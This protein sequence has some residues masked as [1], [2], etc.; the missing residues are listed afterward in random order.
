MELSVDRVVQGPITRTCPACGLLFRVGRGNE[1]EYPEDPVYETSSGWYLRKS[2]GTVLYFPDLRVLQSWASDGMIS[3]TDEISKK[4]VEWKRVHDLPEFASLA[5]STGSPKDSTA[6]LPRPSPYNESS[7]ASEEILTELEFIDPTVGRKHVLY[8]LMAFIIGCLGTWFLVGFL[9]P[10]SEVQIPPEP[11]PSKSPAAVI[12]SPK[13]EGALDVTSSSPE[14]SKDSSSVRDA[15][16]KP[17]DAQT[18]AV[19]S[20]SVDEDSVEKEVEAKPQKKKSRTK[21]RRVG[22]K[23]L[24]YDDLMS[25]GN[26]QLRTNPSKAVLTFM[27]A[28]QMRDATSEARAKLGRAYLRSGNLRDAIYHLEKAI[29]DNP[30]YRPALKDLAKAYKKRG[31][32]EDAIRVLRK[33]QRMVGRYS[34]DYGWTKRQLESLG[35]R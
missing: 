5:M 21:K 34:Q 31:S 35:A 15:A 22:G 4:G 19:D 25:R 1:S 29:K 28:L 17:A 13:G 20:P 27:K 9:S 18:G 2:D 12:D 8:I 32:R 3:L 14:D 6:V 10:G 7:Q 26:S 11:V 30:K 24:S 23:R 16:E 33:L